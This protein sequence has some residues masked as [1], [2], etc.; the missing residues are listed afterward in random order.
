MAARILITKNG[1]K[2]QVTYKNGSG[3]NLNG[4]KLYKTKS[5]AYKSIVGFVIS[6]YALGGIEVTKCKRLKATNVITFFANGNKSTIGVTDKTIIKQEVL[7]RK[8]RINE[9]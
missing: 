3:V 8:P 9:A 1:E 2:Y 6:F 7:K 4:D 5:L